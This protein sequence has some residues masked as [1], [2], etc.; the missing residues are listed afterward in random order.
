MKKYESHVLPNF[1]V[2]WKQY[3]RTI[4]EFHIP[5][6]RVQKFYEF[7]F[8]SKMNP[9]KKI[10]FKNFSSEVYFWGQSI[11]KL[12]LFRVIGQK[13]F[14]WRHFNAR[15][16]RN[17]VTFWLGLGRIICSLCKTSLVC[18]KDA[19]IKIN[20]KET[21]KTFF[22][23]IYTLKFDGFDTIVTRSTSVCTSYEEKGLK[24]VRK[25]NLNFK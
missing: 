10:I 15:Y 19:F 4:R 8:H 20:K 16:D 11:C 21:S 14:I 1:L 3:E 23:W 24:A 17:W 25:H 5:T 18:G 22:A 2:S 13:A 12:T 6:L 9:K 7:N